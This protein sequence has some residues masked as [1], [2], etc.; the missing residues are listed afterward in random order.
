MLCSETKNDWLLGKRTITA[1][2]VELSSVRY[3]NSFDTHFTEDRTE[4]AGKVGR[5]WESPSFFAYDNDDIDTNVDQLTDL[6]LGRFARADGG[7]DEKSA[8]IVVATKRKILVLLNVR[9]RN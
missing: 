3:K 8:V 5:L 6:L 2:S 1:T 4:P 7:S 9:A